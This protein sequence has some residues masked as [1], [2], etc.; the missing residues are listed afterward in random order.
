MLT[1]SHAGGAYI[2]GQARGVRGYYILQTD[3]I[4]T[5]I[6][7]SEIVVVVIVNAVNVVP[8]EG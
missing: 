7:R 3:N 2:E 1:R 6:K 5:C 4:F 8:G